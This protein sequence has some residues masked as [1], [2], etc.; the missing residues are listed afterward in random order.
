WSSAPTIAGGTISIPWPRSGASRKSGRLTGV[1]SPS[2]RAPYLT[3]SSVR[4]STCG[5]CPKNPPSE[6]RSARAKR[7][8]TG[9][10]P[11]SGVS[12]AHD[13]LVRSSARTLFGPPSAVPPA[14]TPPSS[15]TLRSASTSS[16]DRICPMPL[17][18]DDELGEVDRLHQ[19]PV[20]GL[21]HA[22]DDL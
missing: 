19:V 21:V 10:A 9:F 1:G 12:S 3:S 2:T 11:G 13:G 4:S 5:I 15:T 22:I 7:S 20:Q 8:A 14:G 18:L 6:T 17:L 16:C